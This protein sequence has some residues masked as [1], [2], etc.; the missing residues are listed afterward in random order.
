VKVAILG[1]TGRMGGGIGRQLS[2]KNQV[3]IGSRDKVRA[4]AAAKG[5]PG[6]TGADYAEAARSCDA[7]IVAVPYSTIGALSPLAEALAEKLVISIVNPLKFEG[8]MLHYALQKGSAAEELQAILPKS[9]VA[10]AFN[11]VPMSMF[12]AEE[13]VPMDVLVAADSKGTYEEAAGLV[14]G[15]PNLRPLYA[16]P[17]SEAQLVER[18][19]ALVL[20][21]AR[22]NE[23]GSLTTRFASKRDG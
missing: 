14:R 19:T 13:P 7:S 16:G 5:I 4:E 10:T 17:L 9:R 3:I 22:W 21:L 6:A 23:T 20:N 8:G 15:I 1:G 12:Q 2:R 11:N 18:I